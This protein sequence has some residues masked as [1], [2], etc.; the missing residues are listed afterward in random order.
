MFDNNDNNYPY[1]RSDA[2]ESN[3][4]TSNN[5]E[6]RAKRP[7][8]QSY[9]RHSFNPNFD[10]NNR[11]VNRYNN[12]NRYDN[13]NYGNNYSSDYNNG[14]GYNHNN[15]GG[16]GHNN[17]G[18][19][20]HNNGGGYNRNN[21]GGYNRNNNGGGYNRN[22]NG[23]G[24]N[25]NNNGGG[26]NRN[27]NGGGYSRNNNG[28]GYNRNNNG[29]GYNRN[30]NGNSYGSNFNR[31]NNEGRSV[32]SQK[33]Q[34]EYKQ[35]FIDYTKP[36]RLNKYLANAGVCSRREAD[37]YIQAGVVKV[38]GEVVTELGTKVIPATDKILFHNTPVQI[39]KKVY[40]LLNK[41]KN[42]VTT[43]DDPQERHTV[44]DFV[45]NACPQRV[46]PVGR[47]DKNT[48]GVILITNDGDLA[49]K[50]TH[51][52]YDKKKIYQ[53]KLDRDFTEEDM[54]KLRDGIVLE[55][56]EIAVDDISYIQ[57]PQ[58]KE[59]DMNKVGVEIHSGRNRIVRRMFEHLGYKISKLDRVYFAGLTK[60]NLGRGKWRF[61]SEA[62][63]N[64]LKMTN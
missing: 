21:G 33:K 55:D 22:N 41:P 11:R 30:I 46:Y 36:V 24:Y 12:G 28:G 47:L 32:Y 39:E 34:Q 1:D 31:N 38:N 53:V 26:Y 64:I 52:K 17:G 19:Y 58:T 57:N 63:V 16:Y 60:K 42:C 51:P 56:G 7:R 23:G 13:D 18:G 54:Q 5:Y 15:G 20:S 43:S 61:L 9:E 25:R 50:L 10:E 40:I 6:Q 4:E 37:D 49:S 45:R 29:G 62:E 59:L 8:I 14:N 48:T 35:D 2:F 27:N 44:L 3:K